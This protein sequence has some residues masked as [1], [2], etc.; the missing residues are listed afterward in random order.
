MRARASGS[1]SRSTTRSRLRQPWPIAATTFL[2]NLPRQPYGPAVEDGLPVLGVDGTLRAAGLGSPAAGRIRAKTG[3]RVYFLPPDQGIVGAQ[4]RI[5]YIDAASGRRLVYAH[6]I[7]D[8][9]FSTP[10][11]IFAVDDVMTAVEAAIQQAY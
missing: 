7:R 3:N 2:R 11:E 4:T 8:V 9:P 1:R 5:R 10:T 6:M